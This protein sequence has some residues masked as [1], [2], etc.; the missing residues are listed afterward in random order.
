MDVN[1]QEQMIN[2]L[3]EVSFDPVYQEE[4]SEL[5]VPESMPPV[6]QVT[7]CSG[8]L[9]VQSKDVG[10]GAVSVTGELKVCVLYRAEDDGTLHKLETQIGFTVKK[11]IPELEA[12]HFVLY[13]GWIKQIDAKLLGDRRLL[14]RANIGSRFTAYLPESV[15]VRVP[16]DAPKTLQ[17]LQNTYEMLLPVC[18]GEKEFRMNE[19]AVLPETVAG[20]SEIL[21]S[22][23]NFRVDETKTVG[24]KAVFKG[25]ALIHILYASA[26]GTLHGYDAELPFSQYVDM[27]KETEDG[28][29]R[30]GLQM[31]SCEIETDGQEDSKRL[32]IGCSIL[33]QAV[34]ST[35]QQMVLYEDAYVT[36]GTLQAQW[37]EIGVRAKLDSQS[38][39]VSGELTAQA[40]SE[41]VIDATVY[42]DQPILRRDGGTVRV[43]MPVFANVI[44]ADKEGRV[45]SRQTKGELACDSQLA[46]SAVCAAEGTVFEQPVCL[47]SFDTVTL[48]MS[49]QFSIDS[50]MG[51]RLRTIRSAVTE[52]TEKKDGS[53]PSLIARRA[54]R[55]SVWE[56]AKSCGSTV[57]AICEANG[58]MSESVQEGAILLIPMQ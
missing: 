42:A 49:A 57:T 6:G 1:F 32:L 45:Q 4:V 41:R 10:S 17:L 13:R 55:E 14:L 48:R 23:V 39:A 15:T 19:E 2:Y 38:I 50:Y 25:S 54:G 37:Q 40:E 31:L 52:Q 11:E 21:K 56:I 26:A 46:Q 35:K 53:R 3:N 22:S 44:Y 8:C 16:Q 9:C 33:A 27:S 30:I 29:V 20:V 5:T 24:D 12:E 58:L 51:T 34:V 18:C 7:D 43:I 36:R 47:A 28:E